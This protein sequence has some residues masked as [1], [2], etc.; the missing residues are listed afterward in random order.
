MEGGSLFNPGF[1]G[2]NFQWWVGQV[3]DD[4]SWRKNHKEAKFQNKE[5]I[6]GWGY[7][8]KV[9][10]IGLHDRD[11]ETIESDQLPWAQVMY[12]ITAGGGQGS[13]YQTPAIRQGNFVFG[14]FLDDA[15]QQVP[16]IMGILGANAK[17]EKKK[18]TGKNG[19]ENFTPQSGH[20]DTGDDTKI[21][22]DTDLQTEQ[23]AGNSPP[24]KESLDSTLQE[25]AADKK[26]KEVLDKKHPLSC[27]DPIKMPPMKGIQTTLQ[28][29]TK[30]IQKI[31]K[32]LT[33][34]AEAVSTS[35]D[36]LN[37]IGDLIKSAACDIAKFLKTLLGMIQ[38][39]ITNLF[40]KLLEPVVKISPPTIR[41][42]LLDKMIKGLETIA[43]LFNAIGLDLCKSAE[44]S[45]NNAMQRRSQQNPPPAGTPEQLA[46]LPWLP[47][48]DYY[49]PEPICSAE[50]I[51]GDIL[52]QHINDIIQ[53]TNAAMGP[54]V[55][56]VQNTLADYGVGGGSPAGSSPS[57]SGGGLGIPNFNVPNIPGL[58]T[59]TT[60]L[61]LAANLA[62]GGSP[63]DV[64]SN[65]D[66]LA[67]LGGFDLSSAMSFVSMLAELFSCDPR[68]KC[69]P[70]DT[71]TLKE[72]GNGKPSSDKPNDVSVAQAAFERALA[73]STGGGTLTGAGTQSEANY[74]LPSDVG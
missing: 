66:S 60:G 74:N 7:R 45:I 61:G 54:V 16:V 70:N 43:C 25:T 36:Q 19:G 40:D 2:S 28:N 4:S 3:A 37:S 50:E 32:A 14:F 63:L 33:D 29:L 64:A 52:G 69:S 35:I 44:N 42:E 48:D 58:D 20:A 30:K 31:Q 71:H 67:A 26:K 12:P 22:P 65:I 9:R 59:A 6:P 72:G 10:I 8:Y 15:D 1:L 38:D 51:V 68:P 24:S 23:P 46:N 49:N 41:I 62:G 53:G 39:F 56:Q 18:V 21:V 73:G 47:P 34:Y 57:R 17:T 11:E 27:P 13:A 5:E 55:D